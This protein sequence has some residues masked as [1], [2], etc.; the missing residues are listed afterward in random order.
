MKGDLGIIEIHHCKSQTAGV[1]GWGV[2]EKGR[3]GV[4]KLETKNIS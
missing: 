4:V 3:E 2:N 1:T